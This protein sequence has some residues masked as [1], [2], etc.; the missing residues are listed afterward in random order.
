[1]EDKEDEELLNIY[2]IFWERKDLS[3]E[4]KI[5][6]IQ[7]NKAMDYS[8]YSR[9]TLITIRESKLTDIQDGFRPGHSLRELK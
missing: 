7:K 2:N 8:N 9:N 3:A 5:G 4:Q 1:M 6:I